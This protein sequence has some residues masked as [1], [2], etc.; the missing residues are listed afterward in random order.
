MIEYATRI[1][2]QARPQISTEMISAANKQ[3]R[4]FTADDEI[5]HRRAQRLKT[6]PQ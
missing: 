5:L 1:H 4:S 6:R 2:L 3:I